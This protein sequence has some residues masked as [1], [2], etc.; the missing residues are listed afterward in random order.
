[1]FKEIRGRTQHPKATMTIAQHQ[2]YHPGHA[3]HF[4]DSLDAFIRDQITA[5]AKAENC[6]EQNLNIRA[7][8][9]NHEINA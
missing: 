9:R 7:A 1:M 8:R 6:V 4:S 5:R 2:W 3:R